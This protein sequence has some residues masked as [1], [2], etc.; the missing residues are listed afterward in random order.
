M[1][2]HEVL[3]IDKAI[4]TILAGSV[5]TA[6]LSPKQTAAVLAHLA[7]LQAT[8]EARLNLGDELGRHDRMLAG[9]ATPSSAG[10]LDRLL[11]VEEAA[12]ALQVSPR[13]LYRNAKNLPFARK[14]SRKV[15]RFSRA[16]MDRWT[17][18]R[19]P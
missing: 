19:R 16:G 6:G 18:A 5:G 13:W 7:Q 12:A 8:L 15:L 10:C 17:A 9:A 11:T 2:P 1:T 14:L 3:P 4:E